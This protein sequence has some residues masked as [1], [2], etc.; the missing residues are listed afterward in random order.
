MFCFEWFS[1]LVWFKRKRYKPS[2]LTNCLC[3]SGGQKLKKF[4]LLGVVPTVT[5]FSQTSSYLDEYVAFYSDIL[6]DMG[7]ATEIW[8]SQLGSGSA[9]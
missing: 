1:S 9:H 2:C 8:H 6:S 3:P 4:I 7:I 5:L